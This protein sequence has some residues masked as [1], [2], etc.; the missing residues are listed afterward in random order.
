MIFLRGI[1]GMAGGFCGLNSVCW[2]GGGFLWVCGWIIGMAGG[3][4]RWEWPGSHRGRRRMGGRGGRD[5]R[6]KVFEEVG[7]VVADQA[8]F[9]VDVGVFGEGLG[10]AR[11]VGVEALLDDGD[12]FGWCWIWIWEGDE[13]A[14]AEGFEVRD[15]AGGIE[16]GEVGE[17]FWE[18]NL[19]YVDGLLGNLRLP[20]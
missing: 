2:N 19:K 8:P 18:G 13:A 5:E 20:R 16:G 14:I 9:D 11:E 7:E 12:E 6:A 10:A 1:V 15:F 17:V 3:C 4:E